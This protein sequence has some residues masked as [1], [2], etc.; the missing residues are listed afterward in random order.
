MNLTAHPS[1]GIAAGSPADCAREDDARGIEQL[2]ASARAIQKKWARC[3]VSD[4]LRVVRCLRQRIANE[5]ELLASSSAL[6]RN[7]AEAEVQVTE[8]IPFLEAGRFLERRATKILAGKKLGAAGRPAWLR[9]VKQF[10]LREPHGLVLVI[11]PSNYPL[12]LPAV[13]ILQGLVAGN[14]VLVKPALGCTGPLKLLREAFLAAGL[15][16]HLFQILHEDPDSATELIAIGVDKVFLTGSANTGRAVLTQ[17]AQ[18]LT[19]AV[20]ELSGCDAVFVREDADLD[21]VAEAL[22]FGLTLNHGATCVAPRRIFVHRAIDKELKRRLSVQSWEVSMHSPGHALLHALTD[23]IE[24]GA[25]SIKGLFHRERSLVE[26]PLIL[27]NVPVDSPLLRDDFFA[28]VASLV[29][30]RDDEEALALNEKCPYALGAAIFGSDTKAAFRMSRRIVAGCITI[31]DLIFPTADPRVP[32]GGTG[33]SGFGVTRGAEGLLE[34]TFPKTVATRRSKSGLMHMRPLNPGDENLFQSY[35]A[36]AHGKGAGRR[37]QAWSH[38]LRA[39]KHRS[40]SNH[41]NL[42][43]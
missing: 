40:A 11:G 27:A 25:L 21:L 34:M 14:A 17:C 18:S 36:L 1:A 19:P 39:L 3:P 37:L 42:E 5:P 32:F 26:S 30:V 12:F 43:S 7:C 4:R 15:P 38:L 23:A 20:V 41:H 6:I 31:N 9:G 22:R 10:V 35:A 8:I 13:Q 28:P 2:A 24:A 16:E 29:S 33:R